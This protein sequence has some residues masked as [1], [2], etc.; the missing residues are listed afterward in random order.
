MSDN[1]SSICAFGK[2]RARDPRL[3]AV[4]RKACA[5][6]E[7]DGCPRQVRSEECIADF[8]SKVATRRVMEP[9]SVLHGRAARTVDKAWFGSTAEDLICGGPR[10]STA[11]GVGR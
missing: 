7:I 10:P 3:H 5:L 2:G 9:G 8:A 11:H 1:L 4:V 6:F